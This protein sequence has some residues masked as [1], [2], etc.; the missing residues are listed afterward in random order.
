MLNVLE[1]LIITIIVIILTVVY[2]KISD[3]QHVDCNTI[4]EIKEKK[5]FDII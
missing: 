5:L 2:E 1:M 4:P 3:E